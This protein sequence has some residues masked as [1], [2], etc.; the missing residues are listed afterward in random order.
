[1]PSS[2][3]P[4]VAAL[5]VEYQARKLPIDVWIDRE[6]LRPGEQWG[7]AIRRA[8]LDS[9]GLLIFVSPASMRSKWVRTEL[10][11]AAAATDR[12]VV[13]VILEHVPDLPSSL[14]QR[15]WVDFSSGRTP[16]AIRHAAAKIAD[17]TTQYLRMDRGMPPVREKEAPALAESLA[18]E[19]RGRREVVAKTGS[20]PDSVFVVHGHD[21]AALRLVCSF[22]DELEIKPIVLSQSFGQAQSLLQKFLQ[23]SREARFAIV[24]LAADDLGAS[25]IQYESDGIA[26]KALQFRARQNV[27]LELGF[28]YGYLGWENVF[29]VDRKPSR[30]FP[31]F[32][33]PSDLDGA[34]FDTI[35][36]AGQWRETL[37]G[38]LAEAGFEVKIA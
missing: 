27:I 25:R 15:Q 14:A 37:R 38:K 18:R 28:F 20:P 1:M 5:R 13:P 16:E 36:E 23:S 30:V 11:V 4:I 6:E 10:D 26:D 35:D 31:N 12:F 22:L 32:E 7:H 9:F 17:A 2:V 21:D 29:V 3:E 34:V 19:A 8:L 33:R 24:I